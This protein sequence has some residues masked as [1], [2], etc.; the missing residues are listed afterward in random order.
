MV[1]VTVGLFYLLRNRC[2]PI[3]IGVM[4][5]KVY[6]IQYCLYVIKLHFSTSNGTIL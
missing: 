6:H 1:E 5:V 3:K 4:Y 2:F